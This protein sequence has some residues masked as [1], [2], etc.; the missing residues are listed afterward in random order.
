MSRASPVLLPLAFAAALALAADA[1]AEQVVERDDD[2]N[3][4][5]KYVV[6][7]D[8][9]PHGAYH[10][11]FPGGKRVRSRT[12]Y[13]NGL[14]HGEHVENHPTGKLFVKA[15]YENGRL[16][17]P[18]V[19]L[20]PLGHETRRETFDTGL[21][22]GEVVILDK[23][24]VVERQTWDR[25]DIVTIDGRPVHPRSKDDIRLEIE[26]T[27][28]VRDPLERRPTTPRPRSAVARCGGSWRTAR[29]SASPGATWR[30][31]PT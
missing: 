18:R 27:F 20:D 15:R 28:E 19:E 11:F 1:R 21:R 2:G 10:V 22:V 6:D 17:G 30:S 4:V 5:R 31:T 13:R 26:Q 23:G 9:L 25:G 24:E 16:H 29:W 7:E 14:R 3:V 12:Q 8:G